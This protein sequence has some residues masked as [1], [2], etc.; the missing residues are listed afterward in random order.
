MTLSVE[1]QIIFSLN[2]TKQ[3]NKQKGEI[4]ELVRLVILPFLSL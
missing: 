1:F 2:S 4:K 3:F